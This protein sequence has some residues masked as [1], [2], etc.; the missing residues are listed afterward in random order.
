MIPGWKVLVRDIPR[1]A[2]VDDVWNWLRN[3]VGHS[4]AGDPIC[5][6]QI[7]C[8]QLHGPSPHHLRRSNLGNIAVFNAASMWALPITREL[9][10]M[11]TVSVSFVDPAHKRQLCVYPVPADTGA[12]FVIVQCRFPTMNGNRRGQ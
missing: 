9:G 11:W 1:E 7:D 5:E 10:G 8:G 2:R 4:K 12:A 6:R 3:D